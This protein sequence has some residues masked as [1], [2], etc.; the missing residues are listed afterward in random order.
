MLEMNY[1]FK[2]FVIT[3]LPKKITLTNRLKIWRVIESNDVGYF[4]DFQTY[5]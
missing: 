5:C 1:D 2:S 4:V 3:D